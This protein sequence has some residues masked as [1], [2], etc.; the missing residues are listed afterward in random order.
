MPFEYD[1]WYWSSVRHW[2]DLLDPY[3][4]YGNPL[5]AG[6]SFALPFHAVAVLFLLH[7]C[8]VPPLVYLQKQKC[9]SSEKV[10]TKKLVIYNNIGSPQLHFLTLL[11]FLVVQFL[12]ASQLF[13]TSHQIQREVSCQNK[14]STLRA[15]LCLLK[16]CKSLEPKLLS[17]GT[18]L[19]IHKN[20]TMY[21]FQASFI[22]ILRF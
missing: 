4:S 11:H 14:C 10:L 2:T 19:F 3:S 12:H 7:V 17:P 6:A 1:F 5:H 8:G 20:Q 15:I 9:Q 21:N 22:W 16:L 18:G 13:L